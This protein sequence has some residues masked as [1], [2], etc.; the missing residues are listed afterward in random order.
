MK[1]AKA[2]KKKPYV[3][4]DMRTIQ[5]C[6]HLHLAIIVRT[7]W[8]VYGWRHEELGEFLEAYLSLFAELVDN[9]TTVKE[10]V[11]DT[12]EL[13]NIDVVKMLDEIMRLEDE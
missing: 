5:M 12:T 11:T 2:K 3:A 4:P 7:L 13:T 8:M 9:R 10:F 6:N 1:R